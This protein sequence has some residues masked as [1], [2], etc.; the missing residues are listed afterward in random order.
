[1]AFQRV[2][3]ISCLLVLILS[4]RP[5][6]A[7][8]TEAGVSSVGVEEGRKDSLLIY[9]EGFA[10]TVKEPLEWR[11]DIEAAQEYGANIVFFPE[12]AES[13]F[14]DV[15]IRLR[16]TQ[17]V[18]EN[19]AADLEA[20]REGYRREHPKVKFGELNVRHPQYGTFS[21]LFFE[22]G[23]FY[24]YVSYLNPGP[25]YGVILSVSM[26]KASSAATKI[27]LEAYEKV[28][29]SVMIVSDSLK[30]IKEPGR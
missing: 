17:K 19:T 2:G 20:D 15:K 9:G 3:C 13:K 18:D 23:S 16:V 8:K 27:E 29:G 14:A 12:A 25:K 11:G 21:E 22:P 24:E 4:L 1:M 6:E 7:Q 28:L 10:F 5:I 26:S 30:T